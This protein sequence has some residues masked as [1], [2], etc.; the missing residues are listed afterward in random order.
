MV[1]GIMYKFIKKFNKNLVGKT[2]NAKC[3]YNELGKLT[4]GK[5][6]L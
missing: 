5:V 4:F 6:I 1:N 3:F 2:T